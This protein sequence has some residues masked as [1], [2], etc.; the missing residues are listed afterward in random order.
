MIKNLMFLNEFDDSVFYRVSCSCGDP[1]HDAVLYFKKNEFGDVELDFDCSTIILDNRYN[2]YSP[3]YKRWYTKARFRTVAAGSILFRGYYKSSLNF[4]IDHD[5]LEAFE[6][7]IQEAKKRLKND[8]S[9][10]DPSEP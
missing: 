8:E 6:A 7:A 9:V 10:R 2:W 3:W 4:I 5:N 1:E